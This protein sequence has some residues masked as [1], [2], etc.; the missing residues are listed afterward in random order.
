MTNGKSSGNDGLAKEFYK[1][2][3]N[4]LKDIF[5]D[6]VLETKQKKEFNYNSKKLS[7]S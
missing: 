5:A 7:L 2:F 1:T 4:E 3:S 6:S